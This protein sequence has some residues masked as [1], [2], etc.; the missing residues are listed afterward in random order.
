V[1]VLQHAPIPHKLLSRVSLISVPTM[2][3]EGDG[4]KTL[5]N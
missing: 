1:A 3:K 4:C 2:R 5:H